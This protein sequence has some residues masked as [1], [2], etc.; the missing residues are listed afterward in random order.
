M[1]AFERLIKK[2]S[3]HPA[4]LLFRVFLIPLNV[5]GEKKSQCGIFSPL[6]KGECK[7]FRRMGS[8]VESA[9]EL[10]L[11]GLAKQGV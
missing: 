10:G 9:F 3:L 4:P 6:L 7:F 2:N 11:A 1:K 5:K 8:S